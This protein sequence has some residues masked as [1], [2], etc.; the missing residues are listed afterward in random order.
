MSEEPR[1][2]R[3]RKYVATTMAAAAIGTVL[4]KFASGDVTSIPEGAFLGT[5]L[6]FAAKYLWEE[7]LG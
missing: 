4:F 6:G 5:I 2:T 7:N 1:R 3:F